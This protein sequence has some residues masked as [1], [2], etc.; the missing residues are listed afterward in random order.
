MAET[1]YGK[2]IVTNPKALD[3]T[4]SDQLAHHVKRER[5]NSDSNVYLNKDLLPESPV[6]CGIVRVFDVPIPQPFLVSHK[7]DVD[8]VILFVAMSPDGEL[9]TDV[10]IEMGD[11]EEKHTFHRTTAIYVPK[12]LTHCPIYYRNWKKNKQHYL[13]AVLQQPDYL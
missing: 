13:I 2:Y 8:E 10:E 9:G 11:E 6:F 3:M 12:G 1:K 4:R 7:H 5:K